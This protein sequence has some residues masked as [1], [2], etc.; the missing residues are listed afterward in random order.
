VW[1]QAEAAPFATRRIIF[2]AVN[3]YFGADSNQVRMWIAG[4]PDG[5]IV[6]RACYVERSDDP[7]SDAITETA[8]V[9]M[10]RWAYTD[11]V[12]VSLILLGLSLY[13]CHALYPSVKTSYMRLVS[14]Q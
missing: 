12:L 9:E 14:R 6:N 13:I 10:V 7:S 1:I 3:K 11:V 8:D 4:F 2:P 5:S